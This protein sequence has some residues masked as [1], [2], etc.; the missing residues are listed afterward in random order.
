M[1]VLCQYICVSGHLTLSRDGRTINDLR[2]EEIIEQ[3]RL[4]QEKGLT[5][6]VVIG[7]CESHLT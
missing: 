1:Y 2:E 5:N 6:I 7:V 4:I 3:A